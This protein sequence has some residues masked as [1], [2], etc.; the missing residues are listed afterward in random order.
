MSTV[1]SFISSVTGYFLRKQIN[2]KWRVVHRTVTAHNS[3]A[4][5]WT[6]CSRKCMNLRWAYPFCLFGLIGYDKYK[7][8]KG[9]PMIVL[10][11]QNRSPFIL[12]ARF[13]IKKF[14]Q[15]SIEIFFLGVRSTRKVRT[16]QPQTR[17]HLRHHTCSWSPR[18]D[19]AWR[20]VGTVIPESRFIQCRFDRTDRGGGAGTCTCSQEGWLWSGVLVIPPWLQA[21][22]TL[23]MVQ[24]RRNNV[25]WQ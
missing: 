24:S 7:Q 4:M 16:H 23:C 19:L 5:D 11:V 10:T 20:G 2:H 6:W 18:L 14:A 15:Y 17:V 12:V 1:F 21:C 22:L 25:M 3:T 8:Y 9:L 13:W